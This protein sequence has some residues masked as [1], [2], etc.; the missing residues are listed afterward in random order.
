MDGVAE[1]SAPR[2]AAGVH[3]LPTTP[4]LSKGTLGSWL[5]VARWGESVILDSGRAG[6]SS[7]YRFA[8]MIFLKE[9]DSCEQTGLTGTASPPT[10]THTPQGISFCLRLTS[11]SVIVPCQRRDEQDLGCLLGRVPAAHLGGDSEA[12]GRGRLG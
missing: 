7:P 12:P 8:L 1:S 11:K 6:R 10:P 5:R 4:S 2:T 3:V 9:K